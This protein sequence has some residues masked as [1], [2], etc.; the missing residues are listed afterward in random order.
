MI[1]FFIR[2]TAIVTCLLSISSIFNGAH[3]Y[4]ELMSHFKLQYFIAAGV[5]LLLFII[6]RHFK[7]AAIMAVITILNGAYVLPWYVGAQSA[8]GNNGIQLTVM[9]SNVHTSNNQYQKLIDLVHAE[10]PDLLVTQEVNKRWITEL[11]KLSTRYP[12][13]YTVPRQDNFGIAL[14]SKHPFENVAENYWGGAQVPSLTATLI[15]G[16]QTITVIATHPLPPIDPQYYQ[17]RNAQLNVVAKAASTVNGPLIL[18]GDLNITM[19]SSDYPI[20]ET[21]TQL[22]NARKGFGLLPTWP[23]K[24][25]PVMIPIDHCLVSAH[26][27]VRDFSVV[28]DIGSDHLPIIVRLEL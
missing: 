18:I 9:H 7:S 1:K 20:L 25:L 24:L 10:S 22:R 15:I 27:S 11:Q 3:R 19:W 12:Y 16:G 6:L 28:N 26:F 8:A 17:A 14:F 23:S 5:C 4:L 21:A 2:A 13:Q